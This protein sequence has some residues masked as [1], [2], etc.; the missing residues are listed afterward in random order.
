MPF[1][2]LFAFLFF[3]VSLSAEPWGADA[4]LA[5]LRKEEK[6]KKSYTLVNRIAQQM[7]W[8]HKKVISPADGPRSHFWPSSSMYTLQAI[9]KHGLLRGIPMGCDRLMRENEDPWVYREVVAP[10]GRTLKLNP[11][12]DL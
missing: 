6:E 4:D 12:P 2:L 11:V 5:N 8:F 7:I 3:I 9:K 10:D 1:K